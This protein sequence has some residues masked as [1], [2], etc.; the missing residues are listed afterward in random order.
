MAA[1]LAQIRLMAGETSHRC[2]GKKYQFKM[3]AYIEH[4]NAQ[5][6]ADILF[7]YILIT[8]LHPNA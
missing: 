8:I 2:Q 3:T 5:K 4:R 6:Q 1:K 7:D